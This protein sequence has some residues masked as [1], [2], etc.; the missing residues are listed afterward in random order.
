MDRLVLAIAALVLVPSIAAAEPRRHDGFYARVG[1]GPGYGVSTLATAAGDSGGRAFTVNTELAA[2]WTVRPGLVVGAGTFPMVAPA[3]SYDGVDPG[4]QHVSGTGP[5]VAWWPDDRGG[6]SVQGG[7]LVAA[8]Y[9]DGGDR[10]GVVGVGVGATAGVGYDRF[11]APQWSVGALARVTAYRLGGVDD[12][13]T[14]VAPA[15][16]VTFTLH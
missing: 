1:V 7:V 5:F 6:L 11:I 16:L 12:D 10:D 3:P 9:L 15:A 14:I 2:G 4:G 13:L 8:G